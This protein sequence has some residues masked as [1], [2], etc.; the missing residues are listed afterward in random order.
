MLLLWGHHFPGVRKPVLHNNFLVNFFG[1][2]EDRGTLM[3]WIIGISLAMYVERM[4]AGSMQGNI[5]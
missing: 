4:P 1:D 2:G 5:F 3:V